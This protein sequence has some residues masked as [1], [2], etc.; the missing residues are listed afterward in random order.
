MNTL[1]FSSNFFLEEF[2][3]RSIRVSPLIKLFHSRRVG[4]G[5]ICVLKRLRRLKKTDCF[6]NLSPLEIVV[7]R[8][9]VFVSDQ[10]YFSL[11]FYCWVVTV[12]LFN[13]L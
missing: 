3:L 11:E 1:I 9:V 12:G 10:V 7:S 4:S 5:E 2:V 8:N 6:R 13:D